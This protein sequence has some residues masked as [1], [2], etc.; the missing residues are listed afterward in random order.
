MA[1]FAV[2]SAS[3]AAPAQPAHAASAA[4]GF[5]VPQPLLT[6]WNQHGAEQ[7]SFGCPTAAATSYGRG[8]LQNFQYG[9]MAWAP[10]QGN[11]MVVSAQRWGSG[12][13]FDWGLSD[14]F[15]YDNW[16]INIRRYT[17]DIHG[18]QECIAHG[19]G[20]GDCGRYDGTVW[21]YTLQ[22]GVYRIAVEGCDGGLR[23]TCR[24]GWTQPIYL[25][26]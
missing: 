16:L 3:F 15:N 12:I 17:D 14:P 1:T 10:D 4:C 26:L 21:W 11:N 18:D 7:G 22:P 9:V 13:R 6:R 24:Q 5:V 2:V 23:R 20:S 8:L 19:G 25:V